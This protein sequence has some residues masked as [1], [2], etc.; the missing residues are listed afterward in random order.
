MNPDDIDPTSN[1]P[2]EQPGWVV[3]LPRLILGAE[4][5]IAL[6]IGALTAFAQVRTP[7]AG[8]EP[9]LQWEF[10]FFAVIF[11]AGMTASGLGSL[12]R[13]LRAVAATQS[14]TRRVPG[15]VI[16][17][18]S[19]SVP[20]DGTWLDNPGFEYTYEVD[21]AVHH[22]E[23][24][25]EIASNSEHLTQR[26]LAKLPKP[27]SAITVRCHPLRPDL[28]TVVGHERALG[29]GGG[30]G[31]FLILLGLLGPL[32]YVVVFSDALLHRP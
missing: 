17:V 19:E 13:S 30:F 3:L 29:V 16:T 24:R 23:I 1:V 2:I 26:T 28:S 27:G 7:I 6:A 15:V 18:G 20:G 21:G 25:S 32:S 22:G 14:F 5:L 4:V 11:M 10:C 8:D 12:N 31:A 9:S